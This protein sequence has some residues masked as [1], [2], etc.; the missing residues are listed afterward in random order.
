MRSIFIFVV[1]FSSFSVGAAEKITW[2]TDNKDDLQYLGKENPHSIAVDT[3]N[4]I[5]R[6]IQ[7][8]DVEFKVTSIT[9]IEYQLRNTPNSCALNRVKTDERSKYSY[10][11]KPIGM[12]PTPRLYFL[13]DNV[14]LPT[15]ILTKQ[16][17]LTSLTQLMEVNAKSRIA[18]LK[19]ASYGLYI[20]EQVR[21]LDSRFIEYLNV[22]NRYKTGAKLLIE[23]L[24]DFTIDNPLEFKRILTQLESP[25]K[26]DSLGFSAENQYVLG[27]IACSQ[28]EIGQYMVQEIN[29]IM[30]SLYSTPDFKNAHI[31]HLDS[32]AAQSFEKA[33]NELFNQ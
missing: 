20:D 24:V 26:P 13:S 8:F 16:G 3:V 11:T 23:G 1:I 27:H 19:D 7:N 6:R 17:T 10:F 21:Q 4:L 18:L 14:N 22:D 9:R 15:T 28:S 5:L 2:L 12:H 29:Q 30:K 25:V 33:L 31:R 32:S